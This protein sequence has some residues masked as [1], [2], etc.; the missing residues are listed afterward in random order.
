MLYCLGRYFYRGNI[1][2]SYIAADNI[3]YPSGNKIP[4]WAFGFIY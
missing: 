2:D 3:E 1:H 4:L